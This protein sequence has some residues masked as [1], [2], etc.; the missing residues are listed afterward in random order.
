MCRKNR[1]EFLIFCLCRSRGRW[2]M[3]SFFSHPSLVGFLIRFI[4]IG[5][6]LSW[7]FASACKNE[8]CVCVCS[9]ASYVHRVEHGDES[10]GAPLI[11]LQAVT[12][13][14][15]SNQQH[16]VNTPEKKWGHF[17]PT[18]TRWI[19]KGD[20]WQRQNWKFHSWD[21]RDTNISQKFAASLHGASLMLL[22]SSVWPFES[23]HPASRLL[24]FLLLCSL[25]IYKRLNKGGN[26]IGECLFMTG[27]LFWSEI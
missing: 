24:P 27:T 2:T 19:F 21:H 9:E 15:Q 10:C 20:R 14:W 5:V 13:P 16:W 22:L 17:G 12:L 18:Q 1:D 7:N 3:F 11:K 23:T 6:D 8:V 26:F 25:N 4:R